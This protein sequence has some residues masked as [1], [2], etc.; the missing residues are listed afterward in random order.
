MAA[1]RLRD[2]QQAF[3]EGV[4]WGVM[5]GLFGAVFFGWPGALA[6]IAISF[7]HYAIRAR[8]G[9]LRR[10]WLLA[11]H[12]VAIPVTAALLFA[13]A[14]WVAW[15]V[16]VPVLILLWIGTP[17]PVRIRPG[18]HAWPVRVAGVLVASATVVTCAFLP[19]RGYAGD[20]GPIEY[21][22]LTL[23]QVCWR[24]E[25]DH[26]IRLDLEADGDAPCDFRIPREMP[27]REILRRLARENGLRLRFR[28]SGPYASLLW[29]PTRRAVLEPSFD[30]PQS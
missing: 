24:L 23:D 4:L 9:R 27:Q 29:G 8:E 22:S 28:A 20:A 18:G 2:R 1:V 16:V 11:W 17:P 19:A 15:F 5:T 25:N 21:S 30:P 26:G 14:P 3:G 13:A 7:L 12:V 10:P 6:G